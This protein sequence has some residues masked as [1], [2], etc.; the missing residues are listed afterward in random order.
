VS[1][2]PAGRK[3]AG[4]RHSGAERQS[5]PIVNFPCP[6][7]LL[8]FLD[9]WCARRSL[10]RSAAIRLA[11]IEYTGAKFDDGFPEQQPPSGR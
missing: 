10:S 3:R 5:D 4:A 6:R 7:T 8:E 2:A 9:A 11:I 1:K